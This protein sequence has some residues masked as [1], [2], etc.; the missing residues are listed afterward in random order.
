MT[1]ARAPGA[2]YL[3]SR[4]AEGQRPQRAL[5]LA[6]AVFG[7]AAVPAWLALRQLGARVASADW[8][9]H[10]LLFG[11]ALAVVGGFLAGPV[12]RVATL[13]LGLAWLSARV[14]GLLAPFGLAHAAASA[15][16]AAGLAATA[17]PKL[18]RGPSQPRNRVLGPLVL[19]L[20]A[21]AAIA[22]FAAALRPRLALVALDL[23]AMLITFM[24]GRLIAA[25]AAGA[26]YR[27]GQELTERV[28][29]RIEAALFATL[30]LLAA[31]DLFVAPV[32]DFVALIAAALSLAR[33]LRW[34]L[35]TCL[36]S[37]NLA[38]LG[39]GYLW[40]AAG[41]ALRAS[42]EHPVW[43]MPSDAL[44]GLTLGAIGALTL[45][46]MGR[47]RAMTSGVDPERSRHLLAVAA[48]VNAAAVSR[49]LA[50][51]TRGAL[52]AELLELAGLAWAGGSATLVWFLLRLPRRPAPAA[53]AVRR[54]PRRA[55]T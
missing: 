40:L 51:L 45:L 41:F 32:A 39:V 31:C 26:F 52:R 44:H 24:G 11:Y 47:V 29:P 22:P 3:E 10:E 9:A 36:R 48:L 21:V 15:A 55:S 2:T 35:W 43:S 42:H 7:G 14:A 16:F 17:A 34:R 27:R 50:G 33:W 13:G 5:F 53:Q 49:L 23:Y 37:W 18:F 4:S 38:A 1:P 25:A 20:L 28:Q 6:A 46:V 12:S 19:A 30:V 54:W 8:H